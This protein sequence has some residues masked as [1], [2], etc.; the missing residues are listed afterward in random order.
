MTKSLKTFTK[1]SMA[2]QVLDSSVAPQNFEMFSNLNI[3][4]LK[5]GLLFP[6]E[7]TAVDAVLGWGERAFCPLMK[8][9]GRDRRE[10]ER[11]EMLGLSSW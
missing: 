11:E 1:F 6:D 2:Q 10:K 7:N 9:S 4:E 3:K 5:V 8:G